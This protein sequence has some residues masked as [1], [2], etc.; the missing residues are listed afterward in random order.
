M[1]KTLS[2]L[3]LAAALP[4]AAIAGDMGHPGDMSHGYHHKERNGMAGMM[5]G[6]AHG[7]QLTDEQRKTMRQVYQE[8][9]KEKR[10]INQRYLDKLSEADKEAMRNEL[11]ASREKAEK[12]FRDQLTPEQQKAFDERKAEQEKRRAE[13]EEFRK[14]KA[15]KEGRQQ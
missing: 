3:L 4:V 9:A 14:W 11:R 15:E 12:T 5:M 8:A 10:E 2:M 13:W 1:R 7:L 6:P